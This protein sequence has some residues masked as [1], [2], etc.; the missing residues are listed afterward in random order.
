MKTTRRGCAVCGTEQEPLFGVNKRN[1]LQLP[2]DSV[3]CPRCFDKNAK[4]KWGKFEWAGR[5]ICAV[6][7]GIEKTEE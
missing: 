2:K 5:A 7:Y 4:L 3:I 6:V 1:P